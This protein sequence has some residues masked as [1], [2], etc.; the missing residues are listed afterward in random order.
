MPAQEFG[1][2]LEL[3]LGNAAARWWAK[4]GGRRDE[5]VSFRA[6]RDV[7]TVGLVMAARDWPDGVRVGSLSRTVHIYLVL[8]VWRLAGPGT[9]KALI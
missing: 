4:A 3:T 1:A 5:V 6:G 7:H 9:V 2:A 8:N